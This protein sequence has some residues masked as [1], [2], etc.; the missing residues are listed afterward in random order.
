VVVSRFSPSLPGAL[1]A[2]AWS[3]WGKH[4]GIC[5]EGNL[6]VY[7]WPAYVSTHGGWSGGVPA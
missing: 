3:H 2:V 4:L 7:D 5:L 6:R 1:E